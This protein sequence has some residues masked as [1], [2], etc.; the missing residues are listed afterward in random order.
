MLRN[1]L[2]AFF[3]VTSLPQ[4]QLRDTQGG[5]HTPAEWANQKAVVLFFITTDW[6]GTPTFLSADRV[7]QLH[8]RGH[9]IGSHSRSHPTRMAALSRAELDGEWSESIARLSDLMGEPVKTA[10]VPGGYY[11]RQVAEAAAGAGIGVLFT[12]EPTSRSAVVDGCVVLGRYVVQRGMEPGWSGGFAAGS[13]AQCWRQ[14]ALWKAKRVAKTLGGS[15]Y[16]KLRQA[17]LERKQ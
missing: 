16:L 14:G 5:I 3:F 1:L 11:S 12:S 10:S 13:P 6:V 2:V 15:G 7:R 8:R 4:F 17:I 9:V